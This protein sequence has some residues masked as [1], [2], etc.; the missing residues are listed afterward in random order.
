MKIHLE[1]VCTCSVLLLVSLCFGWWLRWSFAYPKILHLI[2]SPCDLVNCVLEQNSEP[3]VPADAAS[4][5][6]ERGDSVRSAPNNSKW[7]EHETSESLF[8]NVHFKLCLGDHFQ[9]WLL[10]R[11]PSRSPVVFKIPRQVIQGLFSPPLSFIRTSLPLSTCV[12]Y[13]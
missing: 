12:L 7:E 10:S 5:V 3:P 6:G 1:N 8:T 2:L 13:L 4:S 9:F 11:Q